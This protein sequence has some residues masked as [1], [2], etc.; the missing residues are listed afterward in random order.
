MPEIAKESAIPCYESVYDQRV[1]G[2]K[3]LTGEDPTYL[4]YGSQLHSEVEDRISD[5][6]GSSPEETLIFNSG[7]SA[8][9]SA[10]EAGIKQSSSST[11]TIAYAQEL[12]SGSTRWLESHARTYGIKTVRF[13]AGD[14][15]DVE[16]VIRNASPDLVVAETVG[17]YVQ[18][19]VFDYEGILDLIRT[20]DN[21]PFVILDNT[22]PLSTG[23][24]VYD[25]LDSTD[26]VCIV[27]SGTKAYTFNNET[28]GIAYSKNLDIVQML[29]AERNEGSLPG[30]GSARY[31]AELLPGKDEF[32]NRNQRIF[33]NTG[34][35]AWSLYRAS[36]ESEEGFIV[37][38][39]SLPTHENYH[40]AHV[41]NQGDITPVIFISPLNLASS[42]D[43]AQ[44]IG[45]N[46]NV[47]EHI[48]LSDSFGFD[49]A[50]FFS[51]EAGPY[52]RLAGGADTDTEALGEALY[53]ALIK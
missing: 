6:T 47:R 32:D 14:A 34:R 22:L 38:H 13:E 30:N 49:K 10:V 35:L 17:N 1:A 39:P 18:A 45:D 53:Q 26:N 41:Q 9:R 2:N 50:A 11:P 31:V 48:Q 36:L 28:L 44:K 46:P 16:R 21:N 27:E 8:L 24:N 3:K 5:L 15:G 40:Q 19:P 7:M 43:F 23:C 51:S 29:R 25:A 12:Y 42:L 52:V 4:R 37:D 33:E 20:E